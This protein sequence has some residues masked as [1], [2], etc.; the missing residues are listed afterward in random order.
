VANADG[1]VL[2]NGADESMKYNFRIE[3]P[4]DCFRNDQQRISKDFW[5][6]I[7]LENIEPFTLVLF[8]NKALFNCA[9]TERRKR[10]L[11]WM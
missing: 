9:G 7:D 8:Q 4:F 1:E 2:L 3:K 11:L 6:E 10:L 5:N